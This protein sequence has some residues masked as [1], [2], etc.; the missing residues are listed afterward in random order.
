MFL[1]E[2]SGPEVIKLFSCS[3]QLSMK[4]S[5]QINIRMLTIDGI[6]IFISREIF[7]LSKNE[8]SIASNFRFN[9]RKNLM[10]AEFSMKKVL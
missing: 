6:F 5:L 4:F 1:K 10:S 3:T 8:Y 2:Q 9:N 7:M